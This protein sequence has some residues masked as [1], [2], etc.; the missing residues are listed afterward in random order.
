VC[1]DEFVVD[2]DALRDALRVEIGDGGIGESGC[3]RG[4]VSTGGCVV[5]WNKFGR[6]FWALISLLCFP[7]R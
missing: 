2:L 4:I 7:V 1:I 5:A 6:L 3:L